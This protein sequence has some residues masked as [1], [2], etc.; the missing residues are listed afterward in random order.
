MIRVE[1][2]ITPWDVIGT[3]R[4]RGE[5]LVEGDRITAVARLGTDAA[6]P[7]DGA[8][9]VDGDEAPLMPGLVEAHGHLT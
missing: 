4:F 1:G 6:L 9:L 7:R 2:S 5:E 8:I 3:P